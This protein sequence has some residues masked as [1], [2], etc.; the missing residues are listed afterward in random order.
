MRGNERST[1]HSWERGRRVVALESLLESIGQRTRVSSLAA[2]HSRDGFGYYRNNVS[3]DSMRSTLLAPSPFS[4]DPLIS[5]S[6]VNG[7]VRYPPL[8]SGNSVR[9]LSSSRIRSRGG[10]RNLIS[11]NLDLGRN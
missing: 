10:P 7:T 3:N 8:S 1:S 2:V 4:D 6:F 11:R 5:R 9:E